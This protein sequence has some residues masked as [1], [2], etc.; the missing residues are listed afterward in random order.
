MID[1]LDL[2]RW[3]RPWLNYQAEKKRRAMQPFLQTYASALAEKDPAAIKPITGTF[4]YHRPPDY[5]GANTRG[6]TTPDWVR[7]FA[8]LKARGIDTVIYQ[9]AIGETTQGEWYVYY[10]IPPA[11]LTR[12]ASIQ[13]RLR[14]PAHIEPGI[15]A[16][17]DAAKETGLSVHLGLYNLLKGWFGLPR[18]AFIA[19]VLAEEL[20]MLPDL[21]DL[22]GRHAALAGWYISPEIMFTCHG[23]VRK[24]DMHAFLSRL[25]APLRQATP[26]L[27]IGLSPGSFWNPRLMPK[28]EDFWVRTLT[29]SGVDLLYPQDSVGVLAVS[30]ADAPAVWQSWQR[31]AQRAGVRLWAN[32][33]SF[34][35]VHYGERDPFVAAPFARLLSQLEAA[36]PHVE[37]V[38]TWEAL[39]F[40]RAGGAPQGAALESAYRAFFLTKR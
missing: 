32:C 2:M 22:Y 6:W 8:Y 15:Q 14:K 29:G 27:P 25:T 26:H 17:L 38:V 12:L 18:Q 28:V 36:S 20:S 13:D 34:E 40:P 1:W 7:E 33:E 31:I 10:P 9:G 21:I 5:A 11:T 4:I 23:H 39:Y 30:P 3:M 19:Q 16:I 35:R 37:K 24:V